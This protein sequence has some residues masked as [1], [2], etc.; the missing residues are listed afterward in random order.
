[1]PSARELVDYMVRPL[2]RHPNA[3]SVSEVEGSASLLLELRVHEQDLPVIRGE[4]REMIQALQQ[5]V[6]AS[7]GARKVVLDLIEEDGGA[8]E[9]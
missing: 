8:G 2:L 7:G 1:M 5:I 4:G 6:A 3:L 9:E